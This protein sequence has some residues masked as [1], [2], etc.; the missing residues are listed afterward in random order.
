MK[1]ILIAVALLALVALPAAVSAAQTQK[2]SKADAAKFL[3]DLVREK[4]KS[5]AQEQ[6]EDAAMRAAPGMTKLYKKLAGV[7]SNSELAAA[8]CWDLINLGLQND[9]EKFAEEFATRL[10]RYIPELYTTGAEVLNPML[11]KWF[12]AHIPDKDQCYAV[13]RELGKNTYDAISRMSESEKQE[14]R[15][16]GVD[17]MKT[18]LLMIQ[19]NQERRWRNMQDYGAAVKVNEKGQPTNK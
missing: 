2:K 8:I 18:N 3:Q 7:I 19:L 11:E 10:K 14:A 12:G 1:K 5:A 17:I 6:I 16:A 15:E 4:V 13:L 9:K